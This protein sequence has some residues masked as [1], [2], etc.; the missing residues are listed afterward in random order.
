MP[1]SGTT[2]SAAG[3][4]RLLQLLVER[5]DYD[6]AAKECTF[7]PAWAGVARRGAEERGVRAT[8]EY[9]MPGETSE[10]ADSREGAALPCGVQRWRSAEP[11]SDHLPI[12]P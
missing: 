2:L 3:P 8:V 1:R 10:G 7:R 12:F 11:P 4:A 6:G 5:V 9:A